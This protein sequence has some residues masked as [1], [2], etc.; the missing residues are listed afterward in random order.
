MGIS[1]QDVEHVA[2]LSRLELSEGEKEQFT[3]QLNDI[4]QYMNKLRSLATDGIEPTAHILPMNNI[5]RDDNSEPGMEREL[6]LANAPKQ[7]KGLFE[8]PRII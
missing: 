8:V 3:H 4:L 6:A 2:L 5:F 7:R 1:R